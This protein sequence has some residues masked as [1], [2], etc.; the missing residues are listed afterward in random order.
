MD[1]LPEQQKM[2]LD[3]C[4]KLFGQQCDFSKEGI[5][6]SIK[7]TLAKMLER[8]DEL[9]V[10]ELNLYYQTLS[11]LLMARMMFNTKL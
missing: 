1:N 7:E 11:Q 8:Y 4:E 9:G 6:N 10:N 2:Y 3:V 5:D